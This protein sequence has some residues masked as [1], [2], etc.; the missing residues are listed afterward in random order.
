MLNNKSVFT[1]SLSIILLSAGVVLVNCKVPQVKTSVKLEQDFQNPP[2]SSK[3]RVWW[4]WMN[5][6]ITKAGIKAD[7][8]WMKSAGIGGLKNFNIDLSEASNDGINFTTV[9]DLTKP[10]FYPQVAQITATFPP[11][12][13]K[14]FRITFT[15]RAHQTDRKEVADTNVR[16]TQIAELELYS[17]SR[18]NRFED[19]SGFTA[20]S[21]IDA[22]ATLPVPVEDAISKNEVID[23]SAKMGADGTLSWNP[24]AGDW[25]I[26]R[27][28]YSLTGSTNGPATPAARGYEVDKLSAEAS[29]R[30]LWDF[31]K[32]V[33]ELLSEN[34]YDQ[35]TPILHERG[36]GRYIG[37]H[38][39]GR[40]FVADGME[41]KRKADIPMCAQWAPGE[42]N[43][44]NRVEPE[45]D[46]TY[47]ILESASVFHFYGQNLV[48]AESVT[49]AGF[50]WICSLESLRPPADLE[51]DG[52]DNR[53]I[54]HYSVHQPVVE[55]QKINRNI[56]TY[57]LV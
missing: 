8:E 47:D 7:I 4:H 48:A 19:K 1:L 2:E 27:L 41:A 53:F 30:F 38:E 24:P 16:G 43:D 33:G 28:G 14:F 15:L 6:N 39:G 34:H 5:G 55:Y 45:S 17:V 25:I 31:R 26:L 3:P 35:L 49:T 56:A 29:D 21:D 13:A 22:S 23:L 51:L 40:A 10:Y 42:Y 9:I 18:V 44:N 37:S 12:T 52:S 50:A 57:K 54:I 46:K 32:T 36:M 20:A 11:A